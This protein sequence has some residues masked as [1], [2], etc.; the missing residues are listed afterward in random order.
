[1][2]GNGGEAIIKWC[3]ICEICYAQVLD[4]GDAKFDVQSLYMAIEGLIRPIQEPHT[5]TKP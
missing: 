3:D 5:N 1:M 2:T 4:Y